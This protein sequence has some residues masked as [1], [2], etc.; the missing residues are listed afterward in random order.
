MAYN[1]YQ[2]LILQGSV[3]GVN[4][5]NITP[6]Q[7]RQGEMIEED[8]VDCDGEGGVVESRWVT[9]EDDYICVNNDKYEKLKQQYHDD[10]TD[11]WV[12]Y[13]PLVVTYGVLI[14]EN[15]T[16]CG[17][18]A[19]TG[20]L[21][22]SYTDGTESYYA[23]DAPTLTSAD[24]DGTN[25]T[26]ISDNGAIVTSI[27]QS[28]FMS[29]SYLQAVYFSG[30]E[31]I[32]NSAFASCANLTEAYFPNVANMDSYAFNYCYSLASL[33]ADAC[34]T[35]GFFAFNYCLSLTS[36]YMPQVTSLESYC[37][38]HC[39]AL[40]TAS[41][42]VCTYVNAYCFNYCTS[43]TS[44]SLPLAQTIGYHAFYSCTSLTTIDL[45]QA[46]VLSYNCFNNCN[47]VT[48]VSL[49]QAAYL[50]TQCFCNCLAMTTVSLPNA[51][52]LGDY[53]FM[54]CINLISVYL[55]NSESI[56]DMMSPDGVFSYCNSEL[57]V[58]VPSA[59]YDDYI[60][61]YGSYSIALD[62]EVTRYF[63]EIL[64]SY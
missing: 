54:T 51:E 60:T 22:Y 42:P 14:E 34:E 24:N 33:T 59:L 25:A 27:P 44:I 64:S 1:K 53:C 19:D 2:K 4:W 32:G 56:V 45:P 6:E 13:D 39:S 36:V 62:Y 15:S 43:L 17:Y 46:T 18:V 26:I 30:C 5:V 47:A 10:D 3:D 48:T 52:V 16:D 37:F 12:D 38:N 9:V 40:A 55:G 50:G 49:P 28:A 63:S 8:S 29:C 21:Y 41:F 35:V 7:Y 57:S 20:I 31:F 58:Y 61:A 11:T 23:W